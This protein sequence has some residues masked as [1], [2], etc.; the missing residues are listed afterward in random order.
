[1][2]FAFAWLVSCCLHLGV[3]Y[4][5]DACLFPI[6]WKQ[7]CALLESACDSL[8]SPVARD[9]TLVFCRYLDRY[10]LSKSYVPID[11]EIC[12]TD[13]LRYLEQASAKKT[14]LNFASNV[15]NLAAGSCFFFVFAAGDG[16]I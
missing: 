15:S 2:A 12:W 6:L 9:H 8:V 14:K 13:T 3:V 1:M 7:I 5:A 16:V 11:V 10:I 4:D